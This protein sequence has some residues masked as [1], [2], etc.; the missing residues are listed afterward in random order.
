MFDGADVI[1]NLIGEN[2]ASKRWLE[3]WK[4]KIVTSRIQVGKTIVSVLEELKSFPSVFIQASAIGTMDIG[5]ILI[6]FL[7][8]QK[9]FL[10]GMVFLLKQ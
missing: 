2:I 5:K 1:I 6:L 10:R 4:E 9:V 8:A 3:G 7:K